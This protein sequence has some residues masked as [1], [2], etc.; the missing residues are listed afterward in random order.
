MNILIRLIIEIIEAVFERD[1][2]ER[3]PV[4]NA[5]VPRPSGQTAQKNTY[6]QARTDLGNQQELRQSLQDIFQQLQ[7]GA[8]PPPIPQQPQPQRTKARKAEETATLRQHIAQQEAHIAE[9][10]RRAQ[11]LSEH[12]RE[13]LGIHDGA[14]TGPGIHFAIPGNTPLERMITAGVILGPCKAHQS[15]RL[16]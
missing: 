8:Q 2:K 16:L 15:R 14:A 9:L 3:Q 10:E 1:T 4:P 5:P 6:V 12:S 7:G 11:A 13:H